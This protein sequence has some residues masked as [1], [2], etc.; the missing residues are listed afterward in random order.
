MK[1]K[2][3]TLSEVL[4]TL[5][6]VGVIAALTVPSLMNLRPDDIKMNFIKAYGTLTSITS[7]VLGDNSYYFA[8]GYDNNGNSCRGLNCL[9]NGAEAQT[10][11][12]SAH[13]ELNLPANM[14]NKFAA[15]LAS[16]MNIQEGPTYNGNVCTFT[17]TDGTW[18]RIERTANRHDI[19]I[20]VDSKLV[21]GNNRHLS[22]MNN[23]PVGVTRLNNANLIKDVD[24]FAISINNETGRVTITDAMGQAFIKNPS[25]TTKTVKERETAFK[26]AGTSSGSS[27]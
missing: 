3:F 10:V 17:T 9:S 2:G 18:W 5:G 19:V 23:T 25:Q 8:E 26:K 24:T 21:N 1:K 20:D 4:V 12:T 7:E 11:L 15:I 13:P 16:K 14:N 22:V 6:I 27:V